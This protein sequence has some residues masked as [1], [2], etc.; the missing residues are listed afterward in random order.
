M[1]RKIYFKFRRFLFKRVTGVTPEEIRKMR[2]LK[3][4]LDKRLE[5]ANEQYNSYLGIKHYNGKQ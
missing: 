4:Y 3:K 5:E 2:Y 1:F